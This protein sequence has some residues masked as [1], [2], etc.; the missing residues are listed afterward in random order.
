MKTNF[1]LFVE[2][3]ERSKLF[4]S[5]ALALE[6]TLHVPGMTEFTL[7]PNCVLGLMPESGIVRILGPALPDPA[8]ARGVGRTEVYL[9]VDDPQ[10][11]HARAIE[12]GGR[13][14]SPFAPR[15]WGDSA[16]YCLDPDGHVLAFA[17]RRAATSC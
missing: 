12:A 13:E 4:Y 3:Q 6:P 2:S 14:I 15:N 9:S 10:G 1:I 8:S 7:G 16:A 5:K 17:S 11:A